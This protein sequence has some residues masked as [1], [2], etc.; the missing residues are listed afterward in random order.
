MMYAPHMMVHAPPHMMVSGAPGAAHV[1]MMP[2]MPFQ[3]YPPQMY[4]APYGVMGR[5][6]MRNDDE[7][8]EEEEDEEIEAIEAY[9]AEKAAA[10]ASR[11][12][13]VEASAN[14]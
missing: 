6:N 8:E 13:A 9:A 5:E 14:K 12:V 1:M 4:G 7:E 11:A 10:A 2:H 3:G